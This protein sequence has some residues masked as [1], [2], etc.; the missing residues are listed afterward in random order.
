MTE[1]QKR[2][3]VIM[4]ALKWIGDRKRVHVKRANLFVYFPG[5]I[6]SYG[7]SLQEKLKK[8]TK[9]KP[10]Q[11]C[12][13]GALFLGHVARFNEVTHNAISLTDLETCIP[14]LN[15][16]TQ[17]QLNLVERCFELTIDNN[18]FDCISDDTKRL[19]AI[20]THMLNNNGI[21]NLTKATKELTR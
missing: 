16:F 4:D 2:I 14:L 1:E 19:R 12:A 20:L 21:L 7:D 5:A 17:E 9:N 10:C 6:D 8:F 13:K 11:V 3:A 15:E 18:P